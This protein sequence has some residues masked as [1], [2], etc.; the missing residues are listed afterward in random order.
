MTTSQG[1][2]ITHF[3]ERGD[4]QRNAVGNDTFHRRVLF[5]LTPSNADYHCGEPDNRFTDCVDGLA[6]KTPHPHHGLCTLIG[7]AP[8]FSQLLR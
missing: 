4:E 2:A 5:V 3:R 1:I 7:M 6:R 8:S